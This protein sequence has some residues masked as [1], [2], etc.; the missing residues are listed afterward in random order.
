MDAEG[1]GVI[2]TFNYREG[3][4][5]SVPEVVKQRI[6]RIIGI[7]KSVPQGVQ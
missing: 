2:M 3:K 7:E 1:Y 6:K 4:K 5:V